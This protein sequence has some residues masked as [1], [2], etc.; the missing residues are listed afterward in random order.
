MKERLLLQEEREWNAFLEYLKGQDIHS[1]LEIGAGKGGSISSL[2][3]TLP[4]D[5]ALTIDKEV[6][7]GWFRKVTDHIVELRRLGV[8][9]QVH[10]G[11]S[12]HPATIARAVNSGPYDLVFI[13]AD[14]SYE[15]VRSDWWNYGKL[16]RIIAFHDVIGHHTGVPKLW[17]RVSKTRT[18]RTFETPGSRK[19]IGVIEQ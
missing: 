10:Y 3:K 16:G 2:C 4:V 9:A 5:R 13:D 11:D 6:K 17:R 14:H 7:N 1:I 19:G 12:R 8:D 18:S 15:A